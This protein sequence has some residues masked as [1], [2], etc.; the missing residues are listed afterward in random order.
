MKKNRV[1]FNSS[2]SS[3]VQEY[4][5]LMLSLLLTADKS[6]NGK[7]VKVT[8]ILQILPFRQNYLS[9]RFRRSRPSVMKIRLF[10]SLHAS[11]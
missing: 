9:F 6:I 11:L 10:K 3:D 8:F 2:I 1:D 4:A 7:V 5:W